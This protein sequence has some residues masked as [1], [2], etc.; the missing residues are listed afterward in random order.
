MDRG[1]WQSTVHRVTQNQTW[2]KQVSSSSVNLKKTVWRLRWREEDYT[3][4]NAGFPESKGWPPGSIIARREELPGK[5]SV[6]LPFSWGGRSLNSHPLHDWTSLWRLSDCLPMPPAPTP[7]PLPPIA[8]NLYYD[9]GSIRSQFPTHHITEQTQGSG[10]P[11]VYFCPS[12][13]IVFL[14]NPFQS[15]KQ[16]QPQ[17][18]LSWGA[19]TTM[20]LLCP[21]NVQASLVVQLVKNMPAMQETLIWFPG[22]EDPLEKG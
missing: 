11:Q 14:Q 22:W 4:I 19:R 2:P 1:A 13:E 16:L 5:S 7:P 15:I 9:S 12:G 21:F 6:P 17:F 3:Y 18:I 8:Q 10:L 20:S